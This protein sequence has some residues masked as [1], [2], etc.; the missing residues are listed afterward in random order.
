M[1]NR[2]VP[3]AGLV[4]LAAL[5]LA[6]AACTRWA[7][8]TWNAHER[9]Q[10]RRTF[11][12]VQRSAEAAHQA[13]APAPRT[14]VREGELRLTLLDAIGLALENNQDIQI[15]GYNPLLAETD[16]AAAWAVYDPAVVASNT[17]GRNKRPTASTLDTGAVQDTHLTEDTWKFRM[18]L[19]QRAP[20]GATF[21]LF[22]DMNYLDTNSRFVVPNPQYTTALT[23]EISQP[24]LRGVGDPTNRAAIRIANLTTGVSFTDF[25]Q[26]VMEMVS[27]VTAAYWQLAFDTEMI[28]INREVRDMAGEVL[29]REEVRAKRGISND[30]NIARA[31]AAAATREVEVVRA[32]NRAR[33]SADALKFLLNA[34]EAPVDSG[35]TIAPVEPPRFF[36]T[37]VDRSAALTRALARRPEL[38]RARASLAINRIR[39]NVADRERLPKLDA[40]LRYTL[41]GLGGDLG[42][43]I[44]MQ[45]ITDPV[46]WVA[47]LELEVPL[48]NRAAEAERQRR[49]VEY[50]QTLLEADRLTDQI[51]QEVSV[52]VRAVQQGRDEVEYTL[53]AQQRARK[54]VDGEHVRFE[55]GEL[56]NEELLRAQDNLAAAERDHYLALLNFNLALTELAR[57]TG[58]L[59]EERGIE[60]VWPDD[61]RG[62]RLV[63]LGASAPAAAAPAPAAPAARAIVAE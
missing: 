22:Q 33:S 56:T 45:H 51:L 30:L 3:A 29:R 41:N 8:P 24:L 16:L 62:R 43:A 36:L 58:V 61:Q 44:D 52:A 53:V 47:G 10:L 28:R 15:A 20:T 40:L 1:R 32:E 11:E 37:D 27:K 55:L 59:L 13:P 7:G 46:T 19:Q 2:V 31:A 39:I 26:K 25:R 54:V 21:A 9:A 34:P 12:N 57:A 5:A 60:I 50:E 6:A 42:D 38:E 35:V 18:G 4:A 49:R 14:P 23:A 63:P 48:G 17:F